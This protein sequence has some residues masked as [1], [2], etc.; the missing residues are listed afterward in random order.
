MDKAQTLSHLA[1]IN[2]GSV[3]VNLNRWPFGHNAAVT[4]GI[5]DL[6]PES[7]SE[8]IDFSGDMDAGNFRFLNRLVQE[9]P[10]KATLFVT[11]DWL[12]RTY[13]NGFAKM[14]ARILLRPSVY[15]MGTYR[16]SNPRHKIWAN[17][18]SSKQV[19]GRFDVALHGLYHLG[20]NGGPREFIGLSVQECLERLFAAERIL[21]DANIN[22]VKGIR[23]PGWGISTELL[24]AARMREYLFIA[25]SADTETP[26]SEASAKGAGLSGVPLSFPHVDTRY[27]LVTFTANANYRTKER[28]LDLARI[29]GLVLL[30]SHVATV[31]GVEGLSDEFCSGVSQICSELENAFP[32]AIWHSSLREI[33][34]WQLAVSGLRFRASI[35]DGGRRI[36]VRVRNDSSFGASGLTLSVEDHT[37]KQMR[38]IHRSRERLDAKDTFTADVAANSERDIILELAGDSTS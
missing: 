37:G 9:R 14:L 36:R 15:E 4:L 19:S 34:E 38:V 29:G 35:L 8:N 1:T 30:H 7:S 21:Q 11:A 17:W 33:A 12:Q 13:R 31:E 10:L 32:N 28:A 20:R 22:Y 27:G 18:I 2:A 26:V 3:R 25:G 6:H 16:L 23:P 5:D 24:E